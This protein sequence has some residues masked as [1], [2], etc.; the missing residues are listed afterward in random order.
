MTATI[1]GRCHCGNL[2]FELETQ[3]PPGEICA[4][5]C[6]CGFCRVHGAMTWSDPEGTVTIR[7][8]DPGL[9]QRYRFGLR[10]ADFYLCRECGAYLGA[11][12]TDGDHAWST[13]NLRLTGLA[14]ETAPARYGA[15]DEAERIARRKRAWTPARVVMAPG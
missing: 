7:V 9:L 5:A 15:E 1:T 13:V 6:D 2:S 10:T 4:R 3:V 11:V 12:L 8:A 14:P